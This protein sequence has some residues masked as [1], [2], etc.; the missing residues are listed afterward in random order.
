MIYI[1]IVIAIVF[2]ADIVLKA[3]S[4]LKEKLHK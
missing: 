3:L 1:G 2:G 4:A